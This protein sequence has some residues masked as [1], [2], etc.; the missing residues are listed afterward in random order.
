MQKIK[1]ISKATC[2]ATAIAVLMVAFGPISGAAAHTGEF[3]RFNACPSTN[4]EV[5]N[6]IF[7]ETT[8][9]VVVIGNAALPIVNPV[10]IQGGITEAGGTSK[11]FAASN[12]M[13]LSKSPQPVPGGLLGMLAGPQST[14]ISNPVIKALAEHSVNRVFAT[15]ELA[16]PASEIQI[17]SF[18]TAFEIGTA[19]KLSVKIHLENPLLGK[20]CQIGSSTSP[21]VFNLTTGTTSP[22]PPNLPIK[23]SGGT[24]AILSEGEIIQLNDVVFVDNAWSTPSA[25]HCG[26]SILAPLIDRIIN[27]KLGLPMEAGHNTAVLQSTLYVATAS[28]VNNH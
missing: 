8:G 19:V 21:I 27:R 17:N 28:S 12:G 15:M 20:N 10:T 3:A 26:P 14:T 9:G 18:N 23:G 1:S 16:R 5:M 22:P 6:C 4:P 25:Q 2:A 11:F 7:S 24:L 13:T